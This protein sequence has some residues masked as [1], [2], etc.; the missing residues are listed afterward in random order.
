MQILLARYAQL[1]FQKHLAQLKI[2][3]IRMMY[4]DSLWGSVSSIFAGISEVLR[5]FREVR[6]R[7][8]FFFPHCV[9]LFSLSLLF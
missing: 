7:L 2:D 9:A 5:T 3:W 6:F 4:F 1:T 8:I